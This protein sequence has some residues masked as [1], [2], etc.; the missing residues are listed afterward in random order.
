MAR[1]ITRRGTTRRLFRPSLVAGVLIIL[2]FLA[3]AIAAPVIA[4][5]QVEET[6]RVSYRAMRARP[7]PPSREH[8]LGMLP[9]EV[10][11][12]Q[13]IVW[14]SRGVFRVGLAVVAGRVLIGLVVGLVAGYAGTIADAI[15]MRITDGFLAFPMIAAAMVML[16][17]IGFGSDPNAG[18]L[19]GYL[20]TREELIVQV[21]L[22]L[23]G[24]MAYARL[25]RANILVER[26][27]EYVLSARA[28]G[29]GRGRLLFR[30]LLPNSTQ[31]LLVMM[32][33]DMGA[34]VVTLL[35]FVFIGLIT[36][37]SDKLMQ[38]DWGH[39]LVAARDWVVGGQPF[40]YWY[41]YLPLSLLVVLF[42]AGWNLIGDGLRDAM[43]PRLY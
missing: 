16:A 25:I 13:G 34:V 29:I 21:A 14:G 27:K 42:A 18:F 22:I 20:P 43:D 40:T 15:L 30:H 9:G 3:T 8:P 37:S 19:Y 35:A 12:L 1:L 32:A 31:G 5:R 10:D 4:P 36:F 6:G 26:E 39:M 23:F 7:Q 41:T 24:W 17:L 2:G 38:G 28:S 11:V 33:S